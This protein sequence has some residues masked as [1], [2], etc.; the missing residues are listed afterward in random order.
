MFRI[1]SFNPNV[2]VA[3]LLNVCLKILMKL[4]QGIRNWI[5]YKS[6]IDFFS[7]HLSAWHWI[8]FAWINFVLVTHGNVDD[9]LQRSVFIPRDMSKAWNLLRVTII[10]VTANADDSFNF[11]RSAQDRCTYSSNWFA[12]LPSNLV[13]TVQRLAKL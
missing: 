11:C 2:L 9:L 13:L 4:A 8:S 1:N 5:D 6:P 12:H 3:I 10:L 7:H